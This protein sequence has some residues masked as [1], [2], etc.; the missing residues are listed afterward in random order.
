MRQERLSEVERE[1]AV[2]QPVQAGFFVA[3]DRARR[4]RAGCAPVTRGAIADDLSRELSFHGA[5]P[6]GRSGPI[7]VSGPRQCGQLSGGRGAVVLTTS[8][9]GLQVVTES[10]CL[11]LSSR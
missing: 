1:V 4:R 11:A 3:A 9:F 7:K 10:S 6:L 8:L 5:R 2:S